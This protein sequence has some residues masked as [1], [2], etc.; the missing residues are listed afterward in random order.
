MTK[1]E[2][3]IYKSGR[4]N[5]N[6]YHFSKLKRKQK[7]FLGIVVFV[8]IVISFISILEKLDIVTWNG[9]KTYTGAIDGVKPVESD[10]AVYY[11]DVGQSD[12]TIVI[13]NDEVL[14][15][16]C[17][18]F[19]QVNTIRQS[20]LSL[21]ID[22]I[23]YMVIT[24]QHDDHMGGASVILDNWEVN[25]FLMPKLSQYNNVSSNTYND[26]LNIVFSNNDIKKISAQSGYEFMLGE[27]LVQ[28]LSP[29]VQDE[30]LNNMS[31]VLK[32]TY[33]DTEF[34]FQGDA[35]KEIEDDLIRSGY[36]IDV[37]VLKSGHHGSNTSSSEKYL[38]AVT[39]KVAVISNGPDNSYGHP[40]GSVLE[41]LENNGIPTFITSLDGDIAVTSD[42]KMITVYTQNSDKIFQY[43]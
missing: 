14:I 11:L 25:N 40:N 30:N 6:A 1:K 17:G 29:S 24:H 42:G 20:L 27:A 39:P 15:I 33:G 21:N 19:N 18:T 2:K 22:K 38:N 35:E 12:C 26:L 41:R 16:D 3:E 7:I 32:I 13:C 37:D 23:D 31:V 43:K 10:F 36:D 34:L 4:K 28:I 9:I 5:E 8:I